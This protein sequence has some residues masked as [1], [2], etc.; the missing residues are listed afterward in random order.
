MIL[1][2]CCWCSFIVV[3]TFQKWRAGGRYILCLHRLCLHRTVYSLLVMTGSWNPSYSSVYSGLW[4]NSPNSPR[5]KSCTVIRWD[6]C[7][8]NLTVIRWD[9][10]H[11]TLQLSDDAVQEACTVIR[12]RCSGNL[13][14]YQMTFTPES[15]CHKGLYYAALNVHHFKPASPWHLCS[16]T[17]DYAMFCMIL[18]LL[19]GLNRARMQ[20]W[21]T[22]MQILLLLL[23]TVIVDL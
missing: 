21:L 4:V 15:L 19:D 18:V 22:C 1:F 12:W 7:S 10:V 17:S 2:N 9:T 6:T 11:R 23:W 5:V 14:S 16:G 3:F 20:K 8:Q 13:Y